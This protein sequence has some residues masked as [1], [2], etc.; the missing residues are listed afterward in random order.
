MRADESPDWLVRLYEEQGATLHRLAV[1]LG[2]EEG[3]GRI[4]RGALLALHRRGH[5]LI[6]PA[7]RVEFLQESVVHAARSVRPPQQPLNLP[8][9]E[10][11]R[12]DD[13][14]RAV[15]AL[16]PRMAELIVVSHYL[17]VFGPDLAGI[18]RMSLRG[19]NQKLEIARETLRANL[20]DGE[21]P[22]AGL[23]AL[24]QEITAALRASARTVQA[25]GTD[26]LA[27]ELEQLGDGGQLRFGPRSVVALTIVALILGLVLAAVTN[28]A[29]APAEMPPA[30]PNAGTEPTASR[31]MPAMVRGIPIYY[32]GRQDGA[33]YRE[34]R[35]LSSSGDLVRSAVEALLT[36]PPADPDYESQWDSG[37]V[38]DIEQ[39]A[40]S[41][42]VDLSADAYAD[43]D[44]VQEEE[45][46]RNQIVY[47]VSDLVA[48]P[49]LSVRFRSEGR[50]APGAF[51]SDTGFKREGL[52]PMPL[53]WITTP[54]NLARLSPGET[55]I[56]GTIK[57][58]YGEPVVRIVNSETGKV[59]VEEPAQTATVA[60]QDGWR[61]W[62]VKASLPAG[63]YEVSARVEGTAGRTIAETKTFEVG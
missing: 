31:S 24:S 42:V 50:A 62:S 27:A 11:P 49:D 13:L 2:A 56:V 44:G 48:N 6:D 4:V 23:E 55:S 20:D 35:D 40:D 1:L 7:E 14:L 59:L 45:Q 17:A 9:V 63:R 26:T 53:V 34:L 21:S 18:M 29:V 43:I 28:P 51:A 3:S 19:C 39:N 38:L 54:R 15:S 8:G 36:V 32:I 25:P 22:P 58:G 10:D 46:A 41:I 57:P 37:Q 16:P 52:D 30:S 60:N 12:Q 33:M 47:T 5:R 61:V